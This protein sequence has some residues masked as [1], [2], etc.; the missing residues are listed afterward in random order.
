ML[1][2]NLTLIFNDIYSRILNVTLPIFKESI[3]IIDTFSRLYGVM[4]V[5]LY[6][7]FGLFITTFSVLRFLK[8]VTIGMLY[9]L[10]STIAGLW[11]TALIPGADSCA[12]AAAYTAI[13]ILILIPLYLLILLLQIIFNDRG[14]RKPPKVP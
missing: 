1:R 6:Q 4:T 13:M 7:I 8:D 11:V 3:N 9:I 10:A 12:A 14:G 2:K 5:G